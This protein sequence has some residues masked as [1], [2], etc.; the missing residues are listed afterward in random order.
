MIVMSAS[1]ADTGNPIA[2]T[3]VIPAD[4]IENPAN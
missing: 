2:L 3:V 4:V 1:S